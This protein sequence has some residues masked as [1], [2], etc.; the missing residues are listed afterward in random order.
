MQETKNS[1]L[2][3]LDLFKLIASFFVVF[4]HCHFSGIPGIAVKAI[5]RFAV[6]FFFL[7]SGYFLYGNK[8]EKILRKT[9]RIFRLFCYAFFLF[10]IYQILIHYISGNGT[11]VLTWLQGLTDFKQLIKFIVY[12]VPYVSVHLWF[13]SALVYVYLLYYWIVKKRLSDV[14]IGLSSAVLLILHLI[15]WQILLT[16][17]TGSQTFV[18]RNFL[19]T[20]YPF[21]GIG[22]L[23]KKYTNV[24]PKIS[25]R[26]AL[27]LILSGSLASVLSRFAL[28]EK[29]VPAGAIL[30]ATTLLIYA[31]Q[32]N[33][34]PSPTIFVNAGTYS[35]F[36]YV[37]H[38]IA[39]D[40]I[41]YLSKAA[42][43]DPASTVWINAKPILVCI[44]TTLAAFISN[45][46]FQQYRHLQIRRTK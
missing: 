8:P 22:M 42:G 39:I 43:I 28:G 12:N 17:N 38:P 2:Y 23:I 46:L 44:F 30:T 37:F 31:V 10:L 11:Q 40:L 18:V 14:F 4:I 20:G 36:I 27:I 25:P 34:L 33:D 1:R 9:C 7:C 19:F 29:S 6:P 15:I 35:T 26:K 21:V 5:A 13:L 16:L 3:V 24:L 32:H 41:G 45:L